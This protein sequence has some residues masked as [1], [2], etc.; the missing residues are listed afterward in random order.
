MKP[1]TVEVWVWVLIYGGL[2][3]CCLGLFAAR[4][5]AGLGWTVGIAGALLA[6]VGVLLIYLRSRMRE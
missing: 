2:L 1:A 4:G 6:A 3:L 5:D